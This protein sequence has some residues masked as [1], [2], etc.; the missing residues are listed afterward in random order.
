MRIKSRIRRRSIANSSLLSNV[1]D[2]LISLYKYNNTYNV[3]RESLFGVHIP[4]LVHYDD[5]NSMAYSIEGRSPFLDHRITEYVATIEPADFLKNGLR[6][7]I[8]RIL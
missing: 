4:H 2:S 6:K 3:W 7:Y 1:D 5:R 8:E